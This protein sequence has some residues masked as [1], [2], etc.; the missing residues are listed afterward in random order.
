MLCQ[1]V[2][3]SARVQLNELRPSALF[4]IRTISRRDADILAI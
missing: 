3:P 2:L 4:L 1:V